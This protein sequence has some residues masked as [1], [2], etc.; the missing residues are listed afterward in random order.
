MVPVCKYGMTSEGT[1]ANFKALLLKTILDKGF[2]DDKAIQALE[3]SDDDYSDG[4]PQCAIGGNDGDLSDD[5]TDSDE[6]HMVHNALSAMN[7]SSMSH[8]T[9]WSGCLMH[10]CTSQH[11]IHHLLI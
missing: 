2:A 10:C 11:P 3:V 7:I 6:S 4:A 5:S 1:W 9:F 8:L